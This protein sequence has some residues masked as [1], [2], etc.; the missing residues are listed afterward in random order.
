MSRRI[1][2]ALTSVIALALSMLVASPA[3][4]I[5]QPSVL[6]GDSFNGG[7][8]PVIQHGAD[9]PITTSAISANGERV[10]MASNPREINGCL[11]NTGPIVVTAGI[12]SSTSTTWQ[13][14]L[15]IPLGSVTDC[16]LARDL[17]ISLSADGTRGL[18]TWVAVQFDAA[19]Q[20]YLP[21]EARLAT[22]DWE[23]AVTTPFVINPPQT[24][25]GPDSVLFLTHALAADGS[26]AVVTYQGAPGGGNALARYVVVDMEYP[27]FARV[28]NLPVSVY[29]SGQPIP[30]A[31]SA[32]GEV[33]A[34]GSYRLSGSGG[35]TAFRELK[36]F[37]C[38]AI[39]YPTRLK[40]FSAMLPTS[41]GGFGLDL[42]MNDSGSRVAV[43]W[44][45]T[46]VAIPGQN[47]PTDAL[48]MLV[49]SPLNAAKST[50]VTSATQY[51][52]TAVFQ[53][54]TFDLSPDGS[55]FIFA[56][57]HPSFYSVGARG[58]SKVSS[59]T[60]SS[61]G[62]AVITKVSPVSTESGYIED[63]QISGSPERVVVTHHSG[64]VTQVLTSDSSAMKYWAESRAIVDSRTRV[65]VAVSSEAS[66]MVTAAD[67]D[68]CIQSTDAQVIV[69]NLSAVLGFTAA[70]AISGVASVGK[71]LSVKNGTWNA[72]GTF[73]YQWLRDGFDL[74]GEDGPTFELEQ[75][76]AGSRIT[77]RV[78]ASKP[79]YY[80]R[81]VT[82]AATAIVTG[83]IMTPA[84]PSLSDTT[85]QVGQSLGWFMSGWVPAGG[86]WTYSWKVGGKVVATT[87]NFT[88]R[89]ADV[90]KTITL[91]MTKTL[92]GYTTRSATSVATSPVAP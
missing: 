77:V 61:A 81:V 84:A 52:N 6:H 75:A 10:I 24:F 49:I 86:N 83:G 76:D 37:T 23:L 31:I 82:S 16:G 57:L 70:P 88:P 60:I 65:T 79:G 5:P 48:R 2:V 25:A 42:A 44:G 18:V 1:F 54:G 58:A 43:A 21:T 72:T 33:I 39:C 9:F 26:R 19:S 35:S 34:M 67:V 3:L 15:S 64:A 7:Q 63:A 51:I 87:M 66:R 91:T 55:R 80:D 56:T 62:K 69:S 22:F 11:N 78:T 27:L 28:Q 4:A 17:K 14:P 45:R 36:I 90:G 47:V 32:D 53:Q 71:T 30:A 41:Q 12:V 85:P 68:C 50:N 38:Q 59:G 8:Q 13:G 73:T 29:E 74:V 46:Q 40:Q 20:S 92:A 89:L